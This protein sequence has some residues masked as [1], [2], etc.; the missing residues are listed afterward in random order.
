M[1][2]TRWRGG[3]AGTK[4]RASLGLRKPKLLRVTS[5][6]PKSA[7]ART[8]G[9]GSCPSL[10]PRL[11]PGPRT[12]LRC[13]QGQLCLTRLTC[14]NSCGMGSLGF[15][16]A[17]TCSSCRQAAD[18]DRSNPLDGQRLCQRRLLQAPYSGCDTAKTRQDLG[19]LGKGAADSC[20]PRHRERRWVQRRGT[21]FE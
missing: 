6:K 17:L 8:L 14:S 11:L 21:R 7:R 10:Q 18:S 5:F 13:E 1:E 16:A 4:G 15:T 12:S 9:A 2:K 20:L 19:R 3:A